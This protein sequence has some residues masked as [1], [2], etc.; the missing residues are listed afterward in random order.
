M[1]I[2][3]TRNVSYVSDLEWKLCAYP[4]KAQLRDIFSAFIVGGFCKGTLR[5]P[6][7]KQVH[8]TL[9]IV[10]VHTH[11]H[12]SHSFSWAHLL[13]TRPQLMKIKLWS[14]FFKSTPEDF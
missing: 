7:L 5:H 12:T 6:S 11:T 4:G 2:S 1:V 8:R 3:D 14:V 9:E 10:C 13:L